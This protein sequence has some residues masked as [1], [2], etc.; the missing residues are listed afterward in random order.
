MVNACCANASR[1]WVQIG[2]CGKEIF[3]AVYSVA[4]TIKRQNMRIL[5]DIGKAMYV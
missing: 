5:L 1:S 2:D 4:I 3:M